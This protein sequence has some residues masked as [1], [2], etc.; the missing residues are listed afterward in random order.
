MVIA[1]KLSQVTAAIADLIFP[2]TC[3]ACDASIGLDETDLCAEC[4][5]G[6]SRL[7]DTPYC[8]HCGENR[9]PHL[10]HDGRCTRCVTGRTPRRFFSFARVGAYDGPLKSLILRFKRQYTL[11]R[12]LGR[13]LFDA[14]SGMIDFHGVDYW[15]PIPSHWMRKWHVGFQPTELL[16][17]A[18]VST[19]R[20]EVAP[21]L[22]MRREIQ[23]FHERPGL[24]AA[25]RAIAIR[26]AMEL[27][28]GADVEG[29]RICLVDDVMT[30]GA[31][32]HEARRML[33]A[34]GAASVSAA[35]LARAGRSES[36]VPKQVTGG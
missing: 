28:R 31:T 12:F 14:I 8:R 19:F 15:I 20:G 4:A 1:P 35:V 34:A 24:S 33:V 36:V 29:R 18:A 3:A 11:D 32:L 9:G 30:T 7:V 13:R 10:L 17:R 16:A 2:R 6:L 27:V 23:P 21:L 26:D 25:E 5:V 22:R